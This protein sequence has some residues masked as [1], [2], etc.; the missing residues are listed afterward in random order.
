MCVGVCST[1][2]PSAFGLSNIERLCVC[3]YSSVWNGLARIVW[4]WM[5]SLFLFFCGGNVCASLLARLF[6]FP[7]VHFC[8]LC[9]AAVLGNRTAVVVVI[10]NKLSHI[11]QPNARSQC[12]SIHTGHTGHTIAMAFETIQTVLTTTE[13]AHN[14]NSNN[15]N[16]DQTIPYNARNKCVHVPR[17]SCASCRMCVCVWHQKEHKKRHQERY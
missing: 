5:P 13:R 3:E 15:N 9:D 2:Y 10:V 17:I 14:K 16:N 6:G 7:F 8:V 4:N 12:T 1:S 11:V